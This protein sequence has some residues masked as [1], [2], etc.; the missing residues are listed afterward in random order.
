MPEEHQR[1]IEPDLSGERE[2]Y[3]K[4]T[5]LTVAAMCMSVA[6]AQAQPFPG[7]VRGLVSASG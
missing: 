6:G 1:I 3:M 5:L 4:R 7:S 2:D